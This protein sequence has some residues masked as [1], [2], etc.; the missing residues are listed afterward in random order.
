[1]S[2]KMLPRIGSEKNCSIPR[3]QRL[4]VGQ[5]NVNFFSVKVLKAAVFAANGQLKNKCNLIIII[6]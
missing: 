4:N 6:N 3:Q 5:R 2:N 1:M